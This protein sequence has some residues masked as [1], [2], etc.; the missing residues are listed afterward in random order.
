VK[1]IS[2]PWNSSESTTVLQYAETSNSK[3]YKP[4]PTSPQNS[5]ESDLFKESSIQKCLFGMDSIKSRKMSH[6]LI[7]R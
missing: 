4:S 7:E 1:N 2:F 5:L 6:D 3:N